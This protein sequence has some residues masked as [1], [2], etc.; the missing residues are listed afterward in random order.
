MKTIAIFQGFYLPHVG[1]VERYTFNLAQK[2][3]QA[4]YR[5]I[6][7]TIKHEKFLQEKEITHYATI[8]RLPL[9]G[10]LLKRYPWIKKNKRYKKMMEELKDEKIDSIILN[11]R[12]W[13]TTFL[14]AKFA[15]RKNIPAS[16][17]EHGTSHF[18]MHNKLLNFFACQYEHFLTMRL[19]KWVKDYYGVSKACLDWL[20]HFEI[21][22][23]G[24]FYNAIDENEYDNYK[25]KLYIE[26]DNKKIKI[27]FAG[28]LLVD[29]GLLLLIEAYKELIIKHDN[30]E[31]IIAGDGPLKNEVTKDNTIRYVGELKHDELMK[32]YNQA[33]IF[34]NP[35]Y[36][37]GLPTTV[38]EA[39]MMKCAV[40]ATPIGGTIEII[41]DKINGLFCD[42]KVESI[43][44]NLEILIN[45]SELRNK[46]GENMHN[47]ILKRFTW[48]KTS[49]S[50]IEKLK[51]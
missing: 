46:L 3:N 34:I 42:T 45:D 48:S 7:I 16:V 47:K 17:I 50:V 32:L 38:L 11:T 43:K 39:G 33:D 20:Q 36:S 25:N 37:E 30:I 31:L 23:K 14:G 29:K 9:A 28:R 13:P 26:E 15:K 5:V 1:G 12:F 8:Y 6:I 27:L 2:L 40:I 49:A 19:K 51:L 44:E 21:Q 22:G 24:I 4:G 18:A 35:S 41:D 10:L